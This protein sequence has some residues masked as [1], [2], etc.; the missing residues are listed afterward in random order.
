VVM[1]SPSE[2]L[3]KLLISQYIAV[4][5]EGSDLSVTSVKDGTA[6]TTGLSIACRPVGTPGE[7]EKFSAYFPFN[8]ETGNISENLQEQVRKL[9]ERHPRVVYHNSKHD[10]PSLRLLNIERSAN[11]YDTFLMFHWIYEQDRKFKYSLEYCSKK[12]LKKPGKL[13]GP[14]WTF[15]LNAVGWGPKFPAHIMAEYAAYDTETTLEL[16]EY[17]YPIFKKQGFDG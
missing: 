5:T 17:I 2:L 9:V 3:P 13:K 1:V 4:D 16:F 12:W 10:I 6:M 14:E 11:F 15:W 7:R 8:H